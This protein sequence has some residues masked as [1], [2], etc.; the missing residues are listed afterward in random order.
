MDMPASAQAKGKKRSFFFSLLVAGISLFF[1]YCYYVGYTYGVIQPIIGWALAGVVV[2]LLSLLFATKVKSLSI[3]KLALLFVALLFFWT[4][5]GAAL[6]DPQYLMGHLLTAQWHMVVSLGSV[7]LFFLGFSLGSLLIGDMVLARYFGSREAIAG[8]TSQAIA[9]GIL[10]TAMYLYVASLCS[11]IYPAILLLPIVV[12]LLNRNGYSYYYR[13]LP[14]LRTYLKRQIPIRS[15]EFLFW[16]VLT[17]IL[18]ILVIQTAY[19]WVVE[20]DSLAL[21]FNLPDL[22]L[23]HHQL[24]R[25]P[26]WPIGDSVFAFSFV[27]VPVLYFGQQCLN[28]VSLFFFCLSLPLVYRCSR[29]L[30]SDE[31]LSWLTLVLY[32]TVPMLIGWL[33]LTPKI[34]LLVLFFVTASL[35]LLSEAVDR[36]FPKAT[37]AA[38]VFIG[39]AIAIKFNVILLVPAL[40][41]VM[42]GAGLCSR[43]AKGSRYVRSLVLLL[44]ALSLSF[45]FW[46]ARTYYYHHNFFYP[47]NQGRLYDVFVTSP[48]E[49]QYMDAFYRESDYYNANFG[50]HFTVLQNIQHYFVDAI[51]HPSFNYGLII[52]LA[53][54][55]VL[56]WATCGTLEKSIF[57][58]T[59]IVVIEWYITIRNEAHYM[60]FILPL[61]AMLAARTIVSI[62]RSARILVVS[63]VILLACYNLSFNALLPASFLTGARSSMSITSRQT[64]VLE[65]DVNSIIA[66]NPHAV[67]MSIN[68]TVPY[69]NDNHLHRFDNTR[70]FYLAHIFFSAPT[71][72]AAAAALRHDGITHVIYGPHVADVMEYVSGICKSRGGDCPLFKEFL[73]R[74]EDLRSI[75]HPIVEKSGLTIYQL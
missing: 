73:R 3:Q 69:A 54:L 16:F 67:F 28:Y 21:Y 55:V 25:F 64:Y 47:Y 34:D 46:G 11:L 14:R 12:A 1:A 66:K 24:V 61:L 40:V 32:T 6:Y 26:Y 7:F 68:A 10:L 35:L 62:G 37:V 17:L 57:V 31:R 74:S 42:L 29:K 27:Y 5:F 52:L 19:P 33:L 63:I 65:D 39:F 20:G 43:H 48:Q 18:S 9:T 45:A 60:N 51:K 13:M 44:L 53:F 30:F 75:L 49:K 38:G 36:Y 72:E 4:N 59:C 71:A 50:F 8:Y 58:I 56:F 70:G 23:Q 15:Y 41:V 2:I 22:I